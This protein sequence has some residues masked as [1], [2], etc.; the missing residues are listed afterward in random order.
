M[1]SLEGVATMKNQETRMNDMNDPIVLSNYDDIPLQEILQQ[2]TQ[3][4][5]GQPGDP[6]GG[7]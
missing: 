3:A 6:G 4:I 1:P 2:E 5:T 7:G